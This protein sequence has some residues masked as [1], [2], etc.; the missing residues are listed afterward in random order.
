MMK[1]VGT[2]RDPIHF[3]DL[4]LGVHQHGEGELEFAGELF[5]AFRGVVTRPSRH[6][7]HDHIAR[8]VGLPEVFLQFGRLFATRTAPVRKDIQHDDFALVVGKA[9]L[10][11]LQVFEGELRRRL[12][13]QCARLACKVG[14]LELRDDL[15]ALRR[16]V[17]E[18]GRLETR[19]QLLARV[20]F[21]D[22][23]RELQPALREV[24]ND[25]RL[26]DQ[27][28]LD[29]D[30]Q[31]LVRTD[32]HSCGCVACKHLRRLNRHAK[33]VD[34]AVAQRFALHQARL[35]RDLAPVAMHHEVYGV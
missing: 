27:A 31:D 9:H 35:P 25:L 5:G 22:A 2:P 23:H 26:P 7:Q 20:P 15:V 28:V 30:P 8:L 34:G 11:P 32:A 29:A 1:V 4:V 10:F 3:G 19:V 21:R 16:F 17:S 24:H 33:L 14:H 18:S 13:L 6:A 12:S